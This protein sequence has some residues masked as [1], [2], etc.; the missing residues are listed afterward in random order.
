MKNSI[1]VIGMGYS[2]TGSSA[3]SHLLK[4]YS[5]CTDAG[6]EGYE[7]VLFYTPNG[8]FDL[9]D[10]LLRN[11]SLYRSDAALDDFYKVMH[12]LDVRDFGWLA[13]YQKRFGDGFDKI[14]SKFINSLVEY[15]KHGS[16]FHDFE[17]KRMLSQYLRDMVKFILRRKIISFGERMTFDGDG[18]VR[19]AFVT[20][21]EFYKAAKTFVYDYFDLIGKEGKNVLILDQ[22][23]LPFHL[24]RIDHYFDDDVRCIVVDRDPRD[25]FIISKYLR[26]THGG[27]E[28]FPYDV[29]DFIKF[30]IRFRNMEKM[31]NDKRIMRIRFEDMIYK[32]DDTIDKIERFVGKEKIGE[33]IEPRKI[34]NPDISIKNTQNFR[35]KP[36]WEEEVK[37][38]EEKMREYLY[39]FPYKIKPKIEETSDP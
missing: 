32:Y 31:V 29:N 39:D 21:E 26:R 2:N 15:E 36:E 1:K 24:Y 28:V 16:W 34:F 20:E 5:E 10:E 14:V 17:Y 6:F 12:K 35:I 7:H 22:L 30:Q 23:L 9:E 13:G 38:I 37:P 4:E 27:L 33:H 3:I 11:N 19:Y 18:R 8:L 25:L